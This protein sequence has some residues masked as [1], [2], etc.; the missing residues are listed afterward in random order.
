MRIFL[1]ALLISINASLIAKAQIINLNYQMA[2][3][4]GKTLDYTKNMSFRGMDLE[5]HMFLNDNISV[6][7]LAGWS[8]FYDNKGKLTNHF[9]SNESI[10]FH[11]IPER[12]YCYI[13]TAPIMGIGRYW[14]S[15][16]NP[17]VK[18]YIGLGIG[19]TWTEIKSA[20]GQYTSYASE[21]QFAFAPELGI[22]IPI[23]NRFAF[24]I[25]AKYVYGVKT[26]NLYTMQNIAICVGVAFK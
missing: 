7:C 12:Q 11:T 8:T 14:P 24:N 5:Y 6:G 13:N 10:D 19:T 25:S 17:R 26:E 20:I 23:S 22:M 1:I 15:L 3:P 16:L 2:I 4:L 18:P 21:L 9:T